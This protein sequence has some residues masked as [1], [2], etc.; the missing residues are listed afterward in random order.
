MANWT[1]IPLEN[2]RQARF[3]KLECDDFEKSIT[4]YYRIEKILAD[5]IVI[6]ELKYYKLENDKFDRW[7]NSELG[8]A[9]RVALESGIT[10]DL[11]SNNIR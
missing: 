6:E 2:D 8:M 5:K 7:D 1:I 3:T 11:A 9:I 10:E 4:V